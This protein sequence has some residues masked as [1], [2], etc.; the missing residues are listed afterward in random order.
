MI[1]CTLN[2]LCHSL[3][4]VHN[5]VYPSLH[6]TFFFILHYNIYY[7]SISI[8]TFGTAVLHR[9]WFPPAPLWLHISLIR[10]PIHRTHLNTQTEHA[11]HQHL[12]LHEPNFWR[13]THMIIYEYYNIYIYC[14]YLLYIY[15]YKYL[16]IYLSKSIYLVLQSWN[17]YRTNTAVGHFLCLKS[18]FLVKIRTISLALSIS[19]F[20]SPLNAWHQ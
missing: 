9:R 7:S 20:K 6:F 3:L 5:L 17:K 19:S 8:F 2:M 11:A 1:S 15:I 4:Y 13:W 14:I 18:G 16:S 10:K 12:L